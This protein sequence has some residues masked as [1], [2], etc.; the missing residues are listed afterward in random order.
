MNKGMLLINFELTLN[1]IYL[2]KRVKSGIGKMQCF[3]FKCI[4][5]KVCFREYVYIN[6]H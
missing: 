2:E 1:V 4:Q 6:L 5:Y 3:L